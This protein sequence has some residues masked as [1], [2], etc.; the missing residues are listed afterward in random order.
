VVARNDGSYM[1]YMAAI[2]PARRA[3][4]HACTLR[5]RSPLSGAG[6]ELEQA[7]TVDVSKAHLINRPTDPFIAIIVSK[8]RAELPCRKTEIKRLGSRF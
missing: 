1:L 5:S 8:A 4:H 3:D 6:A 2:S 7:T